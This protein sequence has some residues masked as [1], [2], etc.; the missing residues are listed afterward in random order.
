MAAHQAGVLGTGVVLAVVLVAERACALGLG[1]TWLASGPGAGLKLLVAA[2]HDL[3]FAGGL[4]LAFAALLGALR[5]R[6]AAARWAA[7]LYVAAAVVTGLLGLANTIAVPIIGAP[8]NYR[9]LYYSDFLTGWDARHAAR[10]VVSWGF[11]TA[12]VA[13]PAAL[14]LGGRL[15][16]AAAPRVLSTGALTVLLLGATGA[17]AVYLSLAGARLGRLPWSPPELANP[18]TTFLLSMLG[19]GTPAL[20]TMPTPF[21]PDD[22][23]V[24][25]ERAPAPPPPPPRVRNLL[26]FVLESVPAEYLEPY[27]GRYPVTPE[28]ARRRGHSRLVRNVYA[29]APA[30]DRAVVSILASIYPGV[31]Y[32][33]VTSEFPDVPVASLSGELRRRGYRTAFFN[34]ADV[35][36][37]DIDRFLA[38][39]GFDLV[40]DYR[41]RRC[42][43]PVLVGASTEQWPLQEG[44]ADICT[45][46]SVAEWLER[47][48]HRPFFAMV[49]TTQTHY[50]YFVIGP[51]RD[52][53]VGDAGLNRYLNALAEGDRALGRLLRALDETGQ[54]DDTL[55]VVLGDHG[56]AFGRHGH[57]GHG[58]SVY[59]E[60][61]HVPLV[62][63][64]PRLFRGEEHD[65]VGGLIDV[66]PTV[67]SLLGLPSP[68][69]WQ[70]R[71]LFGEGRSPRV[72]FYSAWSDL[73]FGYR[74]GDRKVIFNASA[75]RTEIYD[76]GRDPEERHDLAAALPDAVR[77]GQQR[78]AAWVQY[79]KALMERWQA[80]SVAA[81]ELA[82]VRPAEE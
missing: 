28:L 71:D 30:T 35:R 15:A 27:G 58:S 26:L 68:G 44:A 67:M 69:D 77:E 47:D 62:M 78:L 41:S 18:T 14:V 64:N 53:G 23:R 70:G 42:P 10:H 38:S 8:F 5:R 74:E 72:F 63:I 9:W 61:V 31:T 65:A 34:S 16:R 51:E 20:F 37:A 1:W 6:E 55:V 49:W 82:V 29:H 54:A 24:G 7:R 81:G 66:A 21:A 33:S 79:Q 52:F 4:T 76:L 12:L 75:G 3:A 57:Y 43:H 56:E 32:L 73:L 45:A 19:P 60:G 59:E 48:R 25:A 17:W 11:A 13:V 36:F 50:P 22:V 2:Y 39:R 46:E 40:Q 80:R